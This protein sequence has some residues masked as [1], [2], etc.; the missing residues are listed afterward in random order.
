MTRDPVELEEIEL[1]YQKTLAALDEARRVFARQ[2]TFEN[3]VTVRKVW[4]RKWDLKMIEMLARKSPEVELETLMDMVLKVDVC[5]AVAEPKA[6][7]LGMRYVD[8]IE[9]VRLTA[10][11]IVEQ[12][13]AKARRSACK[14]HTRRQGRVS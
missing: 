14:K 4:S 10:V 5:G 2:R 9:D 8:E 7:V 6:P 13:L 1:A 11:R 12:Q 3:L